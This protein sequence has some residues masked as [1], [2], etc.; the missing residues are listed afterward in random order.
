[1]KY[2]F[3]FLLALLVTVAMV[4][5]SSEKQEEATAETQETMDTAAE[6][7]MVQCT[8]CEMSME[9]SKMVAY[10]MDGE[11]KY[12]CSEEC[13]ANYLAAK[14]GAEESEEM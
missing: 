9:K 12:F 4:S 5:C 14:E 7:E 1:M 8:G 6:A 3:V 11:T 2:L 13:K 10:E